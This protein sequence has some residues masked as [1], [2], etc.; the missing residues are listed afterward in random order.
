MPMLSWPSFCLVLLYVSQ[1]LADPVEGRHCHGSP[2]HVH[3]AVG[4]DPSTQMT[5]SFASLKCNEK[6]PTGGILIG[7]SPDQLDRL[8]LEQKGALSYE[9]PLPR[10][11][12]MY[13]S[14]YY[15]H[16]LVDNLQPDTKYY[17]QVLV[18]EDLKSLRGEAK[19]RSEEFVEEMLNEEVHEEREDEE[20]DEE[21]RLAPPPYDPRHHGT[22]PDERRIRSFRTAPKV[23]PDSVVKFA[24][25][26]DIGQF[27]HSHGDDGSLT[28]TQKGSRSHDV[29]R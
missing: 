16:V 1:V 28:D 8:V 19:K 26:G 21:R 2:K 18:K 10:Q 22:C 12:G 25:V 24:I 7:T 5:V 14:P 29:N 6:R 9:T 4:A 17:Y 3:I 15:H 20:D 13:Y 23:G 27:D 11:T